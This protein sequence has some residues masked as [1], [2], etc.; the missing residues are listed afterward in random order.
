MKS[1]SSNNYVVDIINRPL[2]KRVHSLV[3]S[4]LF[5]GGTLYYLLGDDH[6]LYKEGTYSTYSRYIYSRAL[7]K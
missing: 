4:Q 6:S 3:L 1:D 2:I 7:F 5:H